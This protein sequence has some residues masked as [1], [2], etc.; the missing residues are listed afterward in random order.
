M[1]FTKGN[2]EGKATRF[3]KGESAKTAGK[4]GGEKSQK[5]K[6]ERRTM[7]EAL[8]MLLSMRVSNEKMRDLLQKM[9]IESD[10]QTNDIAML[11]GV[12]MK[13]TKGDTQAAAFIRDTI[14]EKPMQNIALS[15]NVDGAVNINFQT[16]D[17]FI[18][19]QQKKE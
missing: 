16:V 8:E 19:E 6:R 13:A 14:G 5:L 3:K 18:K 15:G 10:D 4:K 12:M 11:V 2:N 9:G 17:E 7:R 1:A